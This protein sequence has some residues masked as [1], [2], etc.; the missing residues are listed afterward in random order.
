MAPQDLT[1]IMVALYTPFKDDTRAI[2]VEALTAH[3]ESLIQAGVH[4]LVPGGSTGEF[5]ALSYDERKQLIE[6]VLAAAKGRV[7]VVAG[8]GDLST[9]K[10]LDLA[11]H[12][13]EAGAAAT[14]I[15][16][17]FYDSPNLEELREF[18]KE[19]YEVSKIPIMYYNI[20]SASGVKLSPPS[21]PASPTSASSSSKTPPATPPLSPSSS[22]RTPSP[23]RS[24]PSTAGTP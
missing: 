18:F 7:P 12:A 16:P 10:V 24:S 9:A 6:V 1:G 19:V 23:A 3:V 15:V 13:A 4:G 20:P 2:D 14:M 5:T 22:S 17:P 11:K 8:I 21:S